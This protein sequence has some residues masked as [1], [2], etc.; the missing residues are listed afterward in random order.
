MNGVCVSCANCDTFRDSLAYNHRC[1]ARQGMHYG[2]CVLLFYKLQP[3][4][5]D[6]LLISTKYKPKQ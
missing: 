1:D 6:W 5:T 3:T 2:G 4:V